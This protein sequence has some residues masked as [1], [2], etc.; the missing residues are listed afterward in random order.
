MYWV[1]QD[2]EIWKPHPTKPFELSD[3]GNVRKN[4]RILKPRIDE[5]NRRLVGNNHKVATLVLETFISLRPPGLEASHA[6]DDK[7][8]NSITNLSW[9]SHSDNQLRAVANGKHLNARKTHCDNGHEFTE[10]NTRYD[11]RKNGR[12]GRSCRQC[13]R[14]KYISHQRTRC[15]NG[16]EYTTANTYLDAN[17]NQHC[18][19]CR[20]DSMKRWRAAKA[21]AAGRIPHQPGR[22][23]RR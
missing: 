15:P 2:T 4:G 16:H 9:E 5:W 8:N 21:V 14:D 13:Q 7:A 6:D 17:G 23:E 22:P 12:I 11:H 19:K 18:R 10:E 1:Y 20:R 3:H